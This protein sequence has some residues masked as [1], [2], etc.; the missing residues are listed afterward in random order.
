M[1]KILTVILFLISAMPSISAQTE[2]TNQA[3][4][5]SPVNY[6]ESTPYQPR[7]FNAEKKSKPKKE[8]ESKKENSTPENPPAEMPAAAPIMKTNQTIT[9]PVSVFDAKGR[10]VTNLKQTD[11]KVFADG[12]EQEIIK[13]ETFDEP[14]NLILMIDTSPS[15]TFRI[16]EIQNYA[17]SI[18]ELLK[19]EDKVMV[20]E[21]NEKTN[22]LSELT[23]DRQIITKAVR[24][25]KFG[26]GTSLY[27]A[28]K[29]TFKKYVSGISGRTA[30][31]L[32]TDGVDTFSQKSNYA[33]SL[34]AVEESNAAVFPIYFDT[35]D[36]MLKT[37]KNNRTNL[38]GILGAPVIIFGANSAKETAAEYER[39]RM[40]LSDISVLSGGR[41][42]AVKNIAGAEQVDNIGAELR[43]QYQISFR[44]ADFPTKQREQIPVRVNQ[45]NLYVQARG[46][47]ITGKKN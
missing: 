15:T 16:E 9:I 32:L 2:N 38:P 41:P 21:F 18:V 1:Q 37:S 29:N 43:V 27:D 45:P 17:L 25:A 44:A 31:V 36:S 7:R 14:V 28:V 30:V 22:V 23:A 6:S 46:S 11:F 39:G 42:R 33:D 20:I 19:P 13:V 12:A 8:K 34:Q 47:F 24:K 4:T 26:E 10:F 40:Y 3:Q 5:S 35:F